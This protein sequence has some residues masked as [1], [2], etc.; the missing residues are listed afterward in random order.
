MD[1][2]FNV[3]YEKKKRVNA[4]NTG[5]NTWKGTENW[6]TTRL[7]MERTNQPSLSLCFPVIAHV[8]KDV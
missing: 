2:N 8:E 3:W 7:G 4:L 6:H 1:L 5:A